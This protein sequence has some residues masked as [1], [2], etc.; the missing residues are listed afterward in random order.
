MRRHE[1]LK[2][3]EKANILL[4]SR[5]L[6]SSSLIKETT[7]S[8]KG[9][10]EYSNFNK[11]DIFDTGQEV[12]PN[13][14][15]YKDY[16]QPMRNVQAITY[17]AGLVQMQHAIKIGAEIQRDGVMT[18]RLD[19]NG[20]DWNVYDDNGNKITKI[21]SEI[22]DMA[23]ENLDFVADVMPKEI[24][25]DINPRIYFV[26]YLMGMFYM[27]YKDPETLFA[28]LAWAYSKNNPNLNQ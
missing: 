24:K 11:S 8:A 6:E 9:H 18:I 7:F 5:H 26:Q 12:T 17:E 27:R 10:D 1:K 16:S 22:A 13:R 20:M 28:N 14:A 2:I 4:E 21:D 23:T 15:N 3:I 25:A 19:G